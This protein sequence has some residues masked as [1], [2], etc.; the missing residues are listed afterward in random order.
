MP[1]PVAHV[2]PNADVNIGNASDN[3]ATHQP[4]LALLAMSTIAEWSTLEVFLNWVFVKML[5]TDPA[6]GAEMYSTLNGTWAKKKALRALARITIPPDELLVFDAILK[7]FDSAGKDRHTI[8]HW[9]WGHSRAIPDALLLCDPK[10]VMQHH[11]KM[12]HIESMQRHPRRDIRL[13]KMEG[14]EAEE[15][16]RFLRE[17]TLVWFAADFTESLEKIRHVTNLMK[18]FVVLLTRD[19]PTQRD[20]RVFAQLL[21]DTA[22]ASS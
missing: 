2:K 18:L 4:D 6:A 12:Q 14:L 20:E 3:P 11:L 13:A 16:L 10:V 17:K 9:T 8:A 15:A 7:H 22:S 1:K 21:A 5:G 19:G